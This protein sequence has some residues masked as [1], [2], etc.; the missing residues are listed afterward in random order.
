MP[1]PREV[2]TPDALASFDRGTFADR[3]WRMFRTRL[4]NG[5]ERRRLGQSVNMSDGPTQIFF[6]PLDG[7]GCGRRTG[8]DNV[9]SFWREATEICRRI[10]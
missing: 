6:K 2:L 7:I 9:N 4:A 1:T 5:D 10:C 3:Q 8:C